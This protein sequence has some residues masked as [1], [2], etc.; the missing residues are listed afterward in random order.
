MARQKGKIKNRSFL[1]RF[2]LW[3]HLWLG[4]I[5]GVVIVVVSLTGAAL[6]YEEELRLLLQGYQSVA[7]QDEQFS[8]PSQIAES[9]KQQYKLDGVSSVIYRGATRSA[10]VPYYGDRENQVVHFVNPYSGEVLKQQRLDTD[11]FRQM[12]IGHY[13]LWLPRNIGK[14]IVAY[15]TL[16]FVIALITGMIL[17]WPKKWKKREVKNALTIKWKA[18]F[19]RVN[20]D[21]HNVLGFYSLLVALILALTG[22]VY[23]MQWFKDASYYVASAGKSQP[24]FKR[25]VSDTTVESN[26][27]QADEDRLL[28][29]AINDGVDLQTHQFAIYYPRNKSA[30]WGTETNPT[31]KSRW[32]SIKASYEQGSLKKLNVDL[33]FSE[34]NG[35]DQLMRINYDLH[36]GAIG[37]Q[38]TKI[39]AFLVCLI[40]A[41]LPI[42]GFIVWWKKSKNK[43][44]RALRF[45]LFSDR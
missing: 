34:I 4:L 22:M 29:Q 21:L 16:I 8:P 35:G 9:V 43:R 19:K 2:S 15:G 17:W 37:G 31:T 32:K 41:S 40:S 23:G 28:T 38:W 25:F 5:S 39:L 26:Y 10:I 33:P 1:Y 7:L 18:K 27:W 20:Y 13:Q 45:P 24:E 3:L 44:W 36:V 11:F 12:V 14:P 6:V 30:V 42:T